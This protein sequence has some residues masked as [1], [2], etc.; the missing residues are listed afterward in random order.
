[1]RGIRSEVGQVT[2]LALG[3]AV[4]TFAVA[5]LAVDGTRAFLLRRTLQNAADASALAGSGGL[6]SS[7]YY[8]S[9]GRRIVLDPD[10]ARRA[11]LEL[12]QRR[13]IDG[14]VSVIAD[15]SAVQVNL[16]DEASTSFLSLV[17]IR[18]LPVA[19]VARAEPVGGDVRSQNP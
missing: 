12:L 13:G 7:S 5:G 17:G 2:L 10:A 19:V 3:L 4:V 15:A 9:G 1:M 16:R 11:A 8:S 18:G 6:D 14:Q